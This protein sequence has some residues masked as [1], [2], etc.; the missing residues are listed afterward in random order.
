MDFMFAKLRSKLL[1]SPCEAGE[2]KSWPSFG[3]QNRPGVV[4]AQGAAPG[5]VVQ[6]AFAGK[7]P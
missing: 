7:L 5:G 6:W 2:G 4:Q 3:Y 1:A